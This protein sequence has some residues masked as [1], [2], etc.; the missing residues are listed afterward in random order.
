ME[1]NGPATS[2]FFP[3]VSEESLLTL[4]L[5]ALLAL[6]AQAEASS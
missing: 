6:L 4:C 1:I 2:G 5:A 3:Y